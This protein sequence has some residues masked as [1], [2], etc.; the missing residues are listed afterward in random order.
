[1]GAPHRLRWHERQSREVAPADTK[2]EYALV[3]QLDS[4][5]AS[6]AEGC[7]F[8]P[9][10]VHHEKSPITGFFSWSILPHQ[11]T[12]S[13]HCEAMARAQ[14]K[15]RPNGNAPLREVS[16]PGAP[17]KKP[18][19]GL[20]LWSIL[21]YPAAARSAA[22]IRPPPCI[23][24]LTSGPQRRI[25]SFGCGMGANQKRPENTPAPL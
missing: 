22:R 9:R 20:F 12:G 6:D 13:P 7:G 10:R 3:A 19:C 2:T 17:W 16:P 23:N 5:S 25:I 24:R 21:P 11:H 18:H 14:N 15:A 8:D 1:M 4:V